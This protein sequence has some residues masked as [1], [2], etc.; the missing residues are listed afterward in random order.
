LLLVSHHQIIQF[1]VFQFQDLYSGVVENGDTVNIDFSG[2]VDGEEFE[3]GQAEGY[4]LEIGSGSFIPVNSGTSLNLISLT[5]VL[6]VASLPANSSAWYSSGNVLEGMKVDEEKDVV[7]TFPE[8]Y[9]AEELAG[10]EATFNSGTSLNLISLT[11]VLKVA[12][13]PANSSAW[14][15]S[16]NVTTTSFLSKQK[17]TKLNSRKFQN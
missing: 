15:S 4:D 5:F 14:Y 1:L 16:G 6:K 17:L 7:V 11:F 2:S 10:K 12:S 8:E 9:H 3:G 13:L